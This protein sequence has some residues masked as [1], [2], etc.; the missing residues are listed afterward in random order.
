[1]FLLIPYICV[2][3]D[4]RLSEENKLF[5][6][7]VRSFAFH[8]WGY[9]YFYLFS[10][11]FIHVDNVFWSYTTI[12][13]FQ[14]L[15]DFPVGMTHKYWLFFFYGPVFSIV[16]WWARLHLAS[17]MFVTSSPAQKERLA[18]VGKV[19]Y[20]PGPAG[21]VCIIKSWGLGAGA[22]AERWAGKRHSWEPSGKT[23]W[24]VIWVNFGWAS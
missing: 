11:T 3:V 23:Q 5:W 24:Q 20:L 4:N 18:A 2:F 22:W 21:W 1:M 8:D 17:W 13:L 15:L 19:T 14:F 12:P 16:N 9:K 10:E 7:R 6:L